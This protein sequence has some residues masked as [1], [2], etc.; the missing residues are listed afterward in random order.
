[1]LKIEFD[2]DCY[3]C[4]KYENAVRME[5]GMDLKERTT[6]DF[7][8]LPTSG[9]EEYYSEDEYYKHLKDLKYI[10]Y[11]KMYD[12]KKGIK[13]ATTQTRQPKKRWDRRKKKINVIKEEQ[14]L[15]INFD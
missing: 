6:T 3:L 14:T 15:T 2:K 5:E 7:E 1:M 9:E 12:N 10:A 8:D 4:R 13:D 11:E